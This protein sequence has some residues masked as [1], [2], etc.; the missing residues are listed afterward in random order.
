MRENYFGAAGWDDL[1]FCDWQTAMNAFFAESARLGRN[2]IGV[3]PDE[4]YFKIAKN[5]I[6]EVF[7]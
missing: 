2:F 5:R 1:D 7:A 3:E 4:K 6:A